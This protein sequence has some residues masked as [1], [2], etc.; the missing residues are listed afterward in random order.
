MTYKTRRVVLDMKELDDGGVMS[1]IHIWG[2]DTSDD[3]SQEAFAKMSDCWADAVKEAKHALDLG[4]EAGL[5]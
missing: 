5:L 3:A 4:V 1:T 2:N